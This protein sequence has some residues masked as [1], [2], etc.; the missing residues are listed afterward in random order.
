MRK[1]SAGWY[2]DTTSSASER[3]FDGVSWTGLTRPRERTGGS[4][5]S[6]WWTVVAIGTVVALLVGAPLLL[7][8]AP[9]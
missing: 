6:P 9:V 8:F 5:A 7:P 3:W 4:A 1:P 2:A